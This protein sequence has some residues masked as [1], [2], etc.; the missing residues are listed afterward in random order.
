MLV[1][2]T[3]HQTE[4]GSAI[5]P[6][7]K[8]RPLFELFCSRRICL[9]G[10]DVYIHKLQVYKQTRTPSKELLFGDGTPPIVLLVPYS[11]IDIFRPGTKTPTVLKE[12]N[13]SLVFV[14]IW[15]ESVGLRISSCCAH[16]SARS[17]QRR[18]DGRFT[19]VLHVGHSLQRT[20]SNRLQTRGL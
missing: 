16:N 10:L 3:S 5:M 17:K 8:H 9:E 14:C 6:N 4:C 12:Y 1:C 18:G 13:T 2:R 11:N 19:F 20:C 15:I 7:T